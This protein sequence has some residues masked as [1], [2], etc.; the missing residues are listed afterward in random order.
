MPGRFR[1]SLPPRRHLTDPWFR[2]G[3][4]DVTSTVLVTLICAATIFVYIIDSSLL[5]PFVLFP[6]RLWGGQIWRLVTW[7]FVSLPD[8][9]FLWTIVR[10]ALFWY[11]GRE[12]EAQVGHKKFAILLALITVG[13][14][15]VAAAFDIRLD[16][17]RYLELATFV[18][19]I[20]EHPR[21]R[22]F[23]GIPGWVIG[24]VFV[25]AEL[26]DLVGDRAWRYVGVLLVSLVLAA[27][28]GRA[29]GL[30]AEQTWLPNLA[31]ASS[32]R[33]SRPA[34]PVRSRTK[35]AG[36]GGSKQGKAGKGQ[37][38]VVSGPWAPPVRGTASDQAEVDFLLDKIS[39]TGFDS[40]TA[41]EKRRL[42]EASDRL[43]RK[44]D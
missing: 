7:P 29:L 24:A 22:F 1:F 34:R 38:T 8:R 12:L 31:V 9:Q 23:F 39:A 18:L 40:L 13:T 37:P 35:R 32:G 14:G 43:R 20:L 44:Q 27:L 41:D 28:G 15:L 17:L 21:A 19:F 26:L 6:D 3:Q 33:G 30:A 16:G 2:I 36:K 4:L 10:I 11:F 5:E 42:K 25:G